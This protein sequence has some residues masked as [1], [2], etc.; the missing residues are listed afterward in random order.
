MPRS[1]EIAAVHMCLPKA[2]EVVV[3][4]AQL[5]AM[6][7]CPHSPHAD[8]DGS[9]LGPQSSTKSSNHHHVQ[10]I[11]TI[12]AVSL[13]LPP[14]RNQEARSESVSRAPVLL[15]PSSTA[16]ASS[17]CSRPEDLLMLVPHFYVA[18]F[19]PALGQGAEA[20]HL[21]GRKKNTTI[22]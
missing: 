22:G 14:M 9:Y 2:E 17:P 19:F 12:E 18:V 1:S 10:E 6:H 3:W 13:R 5:Q 8:E 11:D 15:T 7:R 20:H 16:V 21:G 4:R